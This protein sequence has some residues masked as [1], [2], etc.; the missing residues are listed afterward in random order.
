MTSFKI[1]RGLSTVRRALRHWPLWLCLLA[2]SGCSTGL[3]L[4]YNH[5]D[6]LAAWQ[7][8]NLV[9]LEAPQKAVFKAAFQS[10]WDWH[11][12]T[13]LPLYAADLR[14]LAATVEQ[15][16]LDQKS[17]SAF[18][19]K[20]DHHTETLWRKA[21]PDVVHLIAS[22]NDAQVEH[23]LVQQRKDIEK[24]EAEH[25]DETPQQ[26]RKRYLKTTAENS[27]AWLGKLNAAQQARIERNWDENLATLPSP[28]QRRQENLDEIERLAGLLA[29]R[30]QPGLDQRLRHFND[31]ADNDDRKKRDEAMRLDVYA[32]IDASQRK[33]LHARLLELASDFDKLTTR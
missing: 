21:E 24:M 10:L 26:R 31:A 12:Q 7:I 2:L 19:D 15:E 6:T 5:L 22:L 13:Q 17:I 28:E 33:H 11:R 1:F 16:G 14:Q 18:I 25:R 9:K 8:G 4:A 3:R 23:F 29:T 30:Q 32:L 27:D 20:I